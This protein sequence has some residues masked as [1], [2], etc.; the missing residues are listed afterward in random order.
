MIYR[1]RAHISKAR[2]A[3]SVHGPD[4][5]EALVRADYEERAES[6]IG[7][8]EDAL[9]D[10]EEIVAEIKAA[11]AIEEKAKANEHKPAPRPVPRNPAEATSALMDYVIFGTPLFGER[12]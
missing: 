10:A 11:I 9:R 12:K 7:S 8:L 2:A 5:L 1:Y 4:I 6:R 3:A